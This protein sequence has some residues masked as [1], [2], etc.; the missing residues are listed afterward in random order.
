MERLTELTEGVNITNREMADFNIPLMLNMR[1]SDY[2]G[3]PQRKAC[4]F[5]AGTIVISSLYLSKCRERD[6]FL[7]VEETWKFHNRNCK[8]YLTFFGTRDLFV[9]EN[10]SMGSGRWFQDDPS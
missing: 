8:W 6:L 10:F 1:E 4:L 2:N 9:E 5:P 3:W 7:Q